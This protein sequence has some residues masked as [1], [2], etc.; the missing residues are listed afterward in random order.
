L[1]SEML[2][3]IEAIEKDKKVDRAFMVETLRAGILSALHK[4]VKEEEVESYEVV[5]DPA[6]LTIS[7]TRDGKDMMDTS[8]SRIAAQAAKQVI[9]FQLR[10]AEREALYQEYREKVGDIISGEVHRIEG[11]NIIV[12]L[13]EVEA[14]LPSREQI[15]GEEYRQGELI[16]AYVVEVRK[17]H[18]G[19]D[20]ILSRTHSGFVKRLFELEVPEISEGI[21]KIKDV[22]REA[23]VRTKLAVFSEDE[24][25]DCVGSCVGMRGQRVKNVV[26]EL[27]GE[28]IDIIRW[29]SEIEIFIRN[30]LAPAELM[31]ITI[32]EKKDQRPSAKVLVKDDQLP[33]AIGKKGQN[34][35]LASRLTGYDLD[36]E[37]TAQMVKLE[38][39]VGVGPKMRDV[40]KA[41]RI[42]NVKDLLRHSA[43]DLEKLEGVGKKTAIK[44]MEAAHVAFLSAGNQEFATLSARQTES[45]A[46]KK[47]KK[48]QI[49]AEFES[50]FKQ[51]TETS[52]SKGD[53]AGDEPK[54]NAAPVKDESDRKKAILE[55]LDKAFDKSKPDES[56]EKVKEEDGN[57]EETPPVDE[58]KE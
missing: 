6:T 53:E 47:A 46:D 31:K 21:V 35:R 32:T 26:E 51:Q 8:F 49:Y 44:I 43:E 24:K 19:P 1:N 54:K 25:I 39:L 34:I 27:G 55:E 52:E 3:T 15:R 57:E 29:S 20:I 12:Y 28:K 16:K 56:E 48:E 11:R 10:E 42:T 30:S 33:L 17:T 22:S 40:L 58:G 5:V 38:D 41:N 13:G 4:M 7:I 23:G 14:I 18:R 50:A 2:A 37:S 45:D 36:V 9:M